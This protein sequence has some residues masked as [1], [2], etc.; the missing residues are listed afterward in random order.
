[1]TSSAIRGAPPA[2]SLLLAAIALVVAGAAE[3]ED[4]L[5]QIL[6]APLV[7]RFQ[8]VSVGQFR[9][10]DYGPGTPSGSSVMTIAAAPDD[11]RQGRAAMIE[12]DRAA[13]AR[14]VVTDKQ[15]LLV[16]T[17]PGGDIATVTLLLAAR[18]GGGVP[19]SLTRHAMI[20]NVPVLAQS[21][22]ICRPDAPEAGQKAR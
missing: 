6:S 4:A 22:G 2:R 18:T 13:I 15:T 10:L 12:Q 1:M 17:T 7:C 11:L 3:A 5:L 21:T 16:G 19:A 9:G 20:G 14:I 8:A